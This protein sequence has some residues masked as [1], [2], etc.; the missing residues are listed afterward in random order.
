MTINLNGWVTHCHLKQV[1]S[2]WESVPT[3][4]WLI[5]KKLPLLRWT[6]SI[7]NRWL[8]S[9]KLKSAL[10]HCNIVYSNL[11][12]MYF[13][14]WVI[15]SGVRYTGF[16]WCKGPRGGKCALEKI[17]YYHDKKYHLKT[18]SES[19][20]GCWRTVYAISCSLFMNKTKS[21]ILALPPLV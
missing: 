7:T 11:C 14:Y 6:P 3:R 5:M 4:P 20:Y 18:H 15:Y 12:K 1:F 19:K 21:R 2:C 10:K 9:S 8:L 17:R 13:V 16:T